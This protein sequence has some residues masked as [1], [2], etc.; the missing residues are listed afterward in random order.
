MNCIDLF[1]LIANRLH[2]VHW[3]V[4]MV[5][6]GQVIFKV[7]VISNSKDYIGTGPQICV[8]ISRFSR[9]CTINH[10]AMKNT[11]ESCPLIQT[12]DLRWGNCSPAYINIHI[13]KN[14]GK[15]QKRH[16]YFKLDLSGQVVIKFCK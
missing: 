14:Y 12:C 13:Y 4:L 7:N 2:Y 15:T 5:E 8:Y 3:A 10:G 6:D 11:Q 16:K 1:R 9:L